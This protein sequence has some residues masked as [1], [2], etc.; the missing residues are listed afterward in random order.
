LTLEDAVRR[1]CDRIGIKGRAIV[2]QHAEP[3]MDVDK[4]H[5]LELLRT[6]LARQQRKAEAKVK[7]AARRTSE[8]KSAKTVK[9]KSTTTKKPAGKTTRTKVK[10]KAE[11]EK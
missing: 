1:V 6:D 11:V 10:A 2:W 7:A 8:S 5:Q 9:K 3:C 4:P